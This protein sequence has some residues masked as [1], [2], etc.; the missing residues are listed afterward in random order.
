MAA[1]VENDCQNLV[2][3]KENRQLSPK[4]AKE[5][6]ITVTSFKQNIFSLPTLKYDLNATFS[7]SVSTYKKPTLTSEWISARYVPENNR[8]MYFVRPDIA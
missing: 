8:K 3:E 7:G 5:I 1:Y 4:V 6:K 2:Q